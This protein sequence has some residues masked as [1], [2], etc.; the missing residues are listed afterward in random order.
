MDE[1]AFHLRDEINSTATAIEDWGDLARDVYESEL[2]RYQTR[3]ERS[4]NGPADG[5]SS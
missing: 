1:I 3:H 2:E 4:P 5:G